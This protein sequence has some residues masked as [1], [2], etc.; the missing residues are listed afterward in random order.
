MEPESVDAPLRDVKLCQHCVSNFSRQQLR[1][2]PILGIALTLTLAACG[3]VPSVARSTPSRQSASSAP[4][5]V[6][7]PD[8]TLGFPGPEVGVSEVYDITFVRPNSGWGLASERSSN[9]DVV[10]RSTD[11]GRTWHSWGAALPPIGGGDHSAAS[12]L[13]VLLGGN[14]IGSN[15]AD[16]VVS[17]TGSS[18]V[19]VSTDRLRSW[20]RVSFPAPVLAVAA[21]PGTSWPGA[22]ASLAI[23][24]ADQPLW[25]L[26]G[27][28]PASETKTQVKMFGPPGRLVL[29]QLYPAQDAWK[30]SYGSLAGPS[31]IGRSAVA[32]AQLVR[33]STNDGYAI[34]DGV[35]ANPTSPEGYAPVALLQRT[36]T[37]AFRWQPIPEP[38][39]RLDFHTPLS[40]V[41]LADL[42][43]GCAGEPAVGNQL[44][45][46][47]RSTDGGASW[48]T[49][50]TGTDQGAVGVLKSGVPPA[51]ANIPI[52]SGYLNEVVATSATSTYV[53]L[54]RGGLLHTT[55]AGELWETVVPHI[56]G[57]GGIQQLDVLDDADA[58]A[59]VG[60]G[61]LWATTDGRHWRQIA[62]A[63]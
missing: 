57:S 47:Q 55:D 20:H 30:G 15:V 28:L 39:G 34:V 43:L 36:T 16:A 5:S 1:P 23:G 51:S 62:G 24:V 29:F 60:G 44:K 7:P 27:P 56:G 11:G 45:T 26:A 12:S 32:Y 18:S 4:K 9:Q 48:T 25:V 50:W 17:A 61:R 13:V 37:D 2:G 38:C 54:G 10:V 31:W 49:A 59:L 52:T 33:L 6:S 53:A 21:A 8:S 63:P 42:W 58:W 14:G 22:P 41:S 35:A 3:S 19:L 46:L 40:V